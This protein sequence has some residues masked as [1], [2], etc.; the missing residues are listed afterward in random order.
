MPAPLQAL[1]TICNIHTSSSKLNHLYGEAINTA[2]HDILKTISST[3]T[4]AVKLALAQSL[5]LLQIITLLFPAPSAVLRKHAENRMTLLH[6]VIQDLYKSMP[7]TLPSSMSRYQS[8][9]LAESCRRTLHIAHMLSGIHSI[10]SHGS[11]ILTPFV[12]A[13]PLDLNRAQ[14]WENNQMSPDAE[15]GDK[16][17]EKEFSAPTDLVSYR[18]LIE[19]WDSGKVRE[20]TQ[21][22]EM[23]LIACKGA[24]EIKSAIQVT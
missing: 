2:V 3:H 4:F 1:H 8:W 9:L 17:W 23:L 22:V 24:D 20:P 12:V 19:L 18:E 15:K 21:F 13:L 16:D 5:L 7:E 14:I 11:F 10:L 6:K